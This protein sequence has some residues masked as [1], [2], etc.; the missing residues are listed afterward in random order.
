MQRMEKVKTTLM[1]EIGNLEQDNSA[2]KSMEK[3]L[4]VCYSFV[5]YP[6]VILEQ[7]G[8]RKIGC[9]SEKMD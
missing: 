2:L 4:T 7:K 1:E 6:C 9:E 8:M 3:E 5:S